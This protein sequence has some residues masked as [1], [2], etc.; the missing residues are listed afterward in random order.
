[1]TNIKAYLFSFV[2]KTVFTI[3]LWSHRKYLS[4]IVFVLSIARDFFFDSFFFLLRIFTITLKIT[5]KSNNKNDN[6]INKLLSLPLLKH[7][8]AHTHT[9]THTHPHTNI[10]N[11]SNNSN[12]NKKGNTNLLPQGI[13]TPTYSRQRPQR[14]QSR[15]ESI[16]CCRRDLYTRGC[17]DPRTTSFAGKMF[18]LV[19][20]FHGRRAT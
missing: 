5:F 10:N 16:N 12:N 11:N 4:W 15:K 7:T 2:L 6:Y 19:V 17:R 14:Q 9:R 13:S 20:A 1:M 3:L 18:L 8:H